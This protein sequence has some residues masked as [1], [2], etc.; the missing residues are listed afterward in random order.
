MPKLVDHDIRRD[1][2]AE[3]AGRV[4]ATQGLESLTLRDIAREDGCSPPVFICNIEHFI[5]DFRSRVK[6]R[7]EQKCIRCFCHFDAD[8][9]CPPVSDVL[10][11]GYNFNI[12]EFN[13]LLW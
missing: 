7:I 11:E 2:I 8:I 12:R 1:Q 13:I 9:G 10:C 4:L 5:Y 6:I 3:A